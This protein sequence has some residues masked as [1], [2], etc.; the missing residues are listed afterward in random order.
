M[1]S[2]RAV[3]WIARVKGDGGEDDQDDGD[4]GGGAEDLVVVGVAGVVEEEV[5]LWVMP[6]RMAM[7]IWT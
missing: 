1:R 7:A 2:L 3:R 6:G 5:V 4:D